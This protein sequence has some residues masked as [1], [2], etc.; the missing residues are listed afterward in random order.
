V[1]GQTIRLEHQ[2]EFVGPDKGGLTYLEGRNASRFWGDLPH[3]VTRWFCL[4]PRDLQ[5][6]DTLAA[7][8]DELRSTPYG[9]WMFRD[10]DTDRLVACRDAALA[11]ENSCEC[12]NQ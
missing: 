4:H 11:K 3:R 1:F 6:V 7:Q 2:I 8:V 5:R 12:D 9:T 10:F